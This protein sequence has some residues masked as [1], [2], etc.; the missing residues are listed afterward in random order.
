MLMGESLWYI[1]IIDKINL[2]TGMSAKT[3][4]RITTTKEVC[5]QTGKTVNNR[6]IFGMWENY[7]VNR[8]QER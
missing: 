3:D 6:N 7:I 8:K 4:K 2:Q 1:Q 5:C